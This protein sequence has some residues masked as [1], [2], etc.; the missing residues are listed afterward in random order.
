[1]KDKLGQTIA[2]GDLVVF[3]PHY[4]DLRVGRI[5]SRHTWRGLNDIRLLLRAVHRTQR[6]LETYVTCELAS[7]VVRISAIPPQMRRAL[8]KPLTLALHLQLRPDR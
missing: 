1:M 5:E 2:L 4:D 3:S 8:D 7:T 6:G